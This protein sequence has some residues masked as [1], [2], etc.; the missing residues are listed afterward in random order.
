MPVTDETLRA[1]LKAIREA[2]GLTGVGDMVSI[3]LRPIIEA[4]GSL[5]SKRQATWV[6]KIEQ[7]AAT[8]I[9]DH[10]VAIVEAER[11]TLIF[12][13]LATEDRDVL[14][15]SII[16]D[17]RDYFLGT[18][19]V[20]SARETSALTVTGGALGSDQQISADATS[21]PYDDQMRAERGGQEATRMWRAEFAPVWIR[22]IVRDVEGQDHPLIVP[23]VTSES[24]KLLSEVDYFDPHPERTRIDVSALRAASS[25]A[26]K[27]HREGAFGRFVF[28]SVGLAT[29]SMTHEAKTYLE[30]VRQIPDAARPFMVPIIVR[31]PPGIT[32]SAISRV[33]G[34]IGNHFSKRFLGTSS[35]DQLSHLIGDAPVQGF[36]VEQ[37]PLGKPVD[38]KKAARLCH[39][40]HRQ[41]LI[42]H[43]DS[44]A[45][46]S[47]ALEG[48]ADLASIR[49]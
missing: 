14:L 3:S 7:I 9:G 17:L 36:L 19:E 25:Q 34:S 33:L 45:Q 15:F 31:V 13:P 47:A 27:F 20:A 40:H 37:A 35:L 10:N 18:V 44:E 24:A 22:R 26:G 38:F 32:S 12:H 21:T 29:L 5:W 16:R 23:R 39:D 1:K 49:L 6:L 43:S 4:A 28:F 41:L 8:Y 42:I 48:G 11:L 30:Q 2:G 46:A